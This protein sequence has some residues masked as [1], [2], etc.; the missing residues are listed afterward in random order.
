MK[1]IS[2]FVLVIEFAL[3]SLREWCWRPSKNL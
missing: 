3:F 2:I 1:I